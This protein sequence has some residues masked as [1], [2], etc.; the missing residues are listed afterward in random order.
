M[1]SALQTGGLGQREKEERGVVS[2]HRSPG[3]Y[4]VG[5]GSTPKA[6]ATCLKI[7]D[8]KVLSFCRSSGK[9]HNTIS[10]KTLDHSSYNLPDKWLKLDL[11]FGGGSCPKTKP[12]DSQGCRPSPQQVTDVFQ[13][14]VSSSISRNWN[15]CFVKSIFLFAYT[16]QVCWVTHM[17]LSGRKPK[18]DLSVAMGEVLMLC[19]TNH[20]M[21]NSFQSPLRYQDIIWLLK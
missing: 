21:N 7:P 5:S 14:P 1:C 10:P 6:I 12:G 20:T 19:K 18:I 15:G 3:V 11:E 16:R 17:D 9:V 2:A 4:G 13:V 8:E